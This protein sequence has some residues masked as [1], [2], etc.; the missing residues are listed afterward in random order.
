M[1]K[2][3]K[4]LILLLNFIGIGISIYYK[5]FKATTFLIILL[6]YL[7]YIFIDRKEMK[8]KNNFN[9]RAMIS[10]NINIFCFMLIFFRLIQVQIFDNDFYLEKAQKQTIASNKNSGNR[11]SIFDTNG[12]SLAF[13]KNIYDLGIDPAR[14]YENPNIVQA[15]EEIIDKPFIKLNKKK[16]IK[17]LEEANKQEKKYKLISRNLSEGERA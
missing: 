15:L 6:L 2:N 14:A 11:G 9:K 1:L 3:F 17:E 7:I 8:T 4:I 12:K 10:Y 5:L 16:F 13:N